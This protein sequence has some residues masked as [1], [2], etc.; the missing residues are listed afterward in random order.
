MI[1]LPTMLLHLKNNEL[2]QDIINKLKIKFIA[3]FRQICKIFIDRL[4]IVLFHR[5]QPN[6]ADGEAAG[7]STA[8][9]PV[10]DETLDNKPPMTMIGREAPW[11]VAP[12]WQ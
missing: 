11:H 12:A 10:C 5:N 4:V 2:P 7:I 1:K 8:A 3:S 6:G 9:V